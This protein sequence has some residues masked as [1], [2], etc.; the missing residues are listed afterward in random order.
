MGVTGNY[1]TIDDCTGAS[2]WT[3]VRCWGDLRNMIHQID[4]AYDPKYAGE[5]YHIYVNNAGWG[6][7]YITL[8]GTI[9][10]T[11][12][13]FLMWLYAV[14]GKAGNQYIRDGDSTLIRMYD[15]TALP[16]AVGGLWA[17]WSFGGSTERMGNWEVLQC[18]GDGDDC[19]RKGETVDWSTNGVT[20]SGTHTLTSAG[21]NFTVTTNVGDELDIRYIQGDYGIYTVVDVVS[22]TELTLTGEFW[23][24]ENFSGGTAI[25]FSI[26]DPTQSPDFTAIKY[27]CIRI[28]FLAGNGVNYPFGIDYLRYGNSITVSGGTEGTPLT[29]VDLEDAVGYNTSH[30]L[31]GFNDQDLLNE[32]SIKIN[33]GIN[34][35]DGVTETHFKETS[36][37]FNIEQYSDDCNYDFIITGDTTVT[38]GEK[39]SAGDK[40]FS[41]NACQLI[42]KSGKKPN[43]IVKGE[44]S[45]FY[46]YGTAFKNWDTIQLGTSGSQAGDIELLEVDISNCDSVQ[47]RSSGLVIN[48]SKIHDSDGTCGL[49]FYDDPTNAFED[50]KVY[51]NPTG[52]CFQSGLTVNL[53]DFL[54]TDNVADVYFN[55]GSATGTLNLIDSTDNPTASQAS[56][57]WNV[58]EKTSYD[59]NLKDELGTGILSAAVRIG[60][61]Q[62]A[63]V[64]VLNT[65]STG[66]VTGQEV[67]RRTREYRASLTTTVHTPMQ[68]RMRK[69]GY[70]PQQIIGKEFGALAVSDS[71]VLLDSD[72]NTTDVSGITGFTGDLRIN[73]AL[74]PD[75]IELTGADHTLKEVF[76][77]TR[78]HTALTGNMD[79]SDP[80]SSVDGVTFYNTDYDFYVSGG[81][82]QGSTLILDMAT[83]DFTTGG[84]GSHGLKKLTDID[85]T[86]VSLVLNNVIVGSRCR[87]ENIANGSGYMNEEAAAAT[88]TESYVHTSDVDVVVKVRKSP[89]GGARYKPFTAYGTI[90]NDGLNVY[91]SQI[92]DSIAN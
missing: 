13:D 50:C 8:T 29:V 20:V 57:A 44:D 70:V 51:S 77:W 23:D 58:Y 27:I 66:N 68:L 1:T 78:Y 3:A 56:E 6:S 35:G 16:S 24:G 39:V 85:G 62:G 48:Q 41:A 73:E 90:T 61:D 87:V 54:F 26:V 86:Q 45:K 47:C 30:G 4:G 71:F 67:T 75:R 15:D 79:L 19:Y 65:D 11:K 83:K 49:G 22:N 43:F 64:F 18:G 17:E 89:D 81:E 10:I 21:N 88:V 46:G 32:A 60:N 31:I 14:K 72:V 59:I 76:E 5:C 2:S 80:I 91:V 42:V 53:K 38:L 7:F 55:H 63:E 28:D 40:D 34:F 36:K 74:S 37:L 25:N 9:D 12:N 84:L 82:L 69:Y 92:E 33:C 52:V